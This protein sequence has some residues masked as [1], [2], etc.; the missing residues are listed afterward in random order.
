MM[1]SGEYIVA[2]I[3]TSSYKDIYRPSLQVPFRLLISI[4]FLSTNEVI[5][6]SVKSRERCVFIYHYLYPSHNYIFL[7]SPINEHSLQE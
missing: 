7:L 5:V 4:S 2:N 1:I 3:L 6:D